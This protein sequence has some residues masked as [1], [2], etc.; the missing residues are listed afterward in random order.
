M[1]FGQTYKFVVPDIFP[2]DAQTA[3]ENLEDIYKRY[4][5][6]TP[7][8]VLDDNRKEGRPLHDC[9]EWDD[10]IAGEKYR[11]SQAGK[12]IRSV[13]IVRK[14]EPIEREPIRYVVHCGKQHEYHPID[15]VLESKD[16]R[17]EM[18]E[19]AR[20]DFENFKRK[21]AVLTALTGFF[22]AADEAWPK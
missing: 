19:N 8:N 5:A 20:R 17:A 14:E 9:F 21:Y 11:L 12:I 7:E 2:V 10:T 4:G 13:V 16:M 22:A 6:I 18:L 1:T 3:G 15:I